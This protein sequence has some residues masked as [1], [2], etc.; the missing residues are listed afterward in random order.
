[1][2]KVLCLLAFVGVAQAERGPALIVDGRPLEA[3]E[4]ERAAAENE[5]RDLERRTKA[6]DEQTRTRR[7]EMRRRVR[8]LY[9]LTAGGYLRLLVSNDTAGGEALR[10]A[11]IARLVRRDLDEL[12]ALVDET[13]QLDEERKRRA[14]ALA[15]AAPGDARERATPASDGFAILR[16]QLGRPVPG[17]V[18]LGFGVYRDE[19]GLEGNRRGVELRAIVGQ[20]VSAAAPGQ[21]RFAGAIPGL[22]LVTAVEHADG[23]VTLTGR[24][25]NLRVAAGDS[26]QE[27]TRLGEAAGGTVF[28]ELAQSDTPINPLPW[29]K[30]PPTAQPGGLP[31]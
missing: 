9:K 3:I 17:F 21:V 13:R 19:D 25:R 27:G 10:D 31:N 12:Q 24:L 30:P 15:M 18:T 8:A 2:K 1:V 23:Y 6:L 22:G 29:L 7:A 4:S 14:A 26:V 28:F 20:A 11:A 5:A 16:G